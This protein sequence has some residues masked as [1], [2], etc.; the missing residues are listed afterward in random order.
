MKS[1]WVLTLLLFKT[2]VMLVTFFV[3]QLYHQPR[4][5]TRI[6]QKSG[7]MRNFTRSSSG[8]PHDFV[9]S[10]LLQNRIEVAQRRNTFADTASV[11]R[12]GTFNGLARYIGEALP[13]KTMILNSYRNTIGIGN[14]TFDVTARDNITSPEAIAYRYRVLQIGSDGQGDV[15][16]VVREWTPFTL[17]PVIEISPPLQ[18]SGSYEIEVQAR[19]SDGNSDPDPAST[20]FTIDV[21]S[22]RISIR[23][24]A[25]FEH[26]PAQASYQVIGNFDDNDLLQ[27][28]IHYRRA[29]AQ[30]WSDAGIT[31]PATIVDDILAV[32]ETPDAGCDLALYDFRVRARDSLG[33]ADSTMLKIYLDPLFKEQTMASEVGGALGS[34]CGT[35]GV[36]LYI[37]PKALAENVTFEIATLDSQNLCET[38]RNVL[39]AVSITAV[40]KSG[41]N[42]LLLE[43]DGTITL[44]HPDITGGDNGEGVMTIFYKPPGCEQ[45]WTPV[46]GTID[47]QRHTITQRFTATGAYLLGRDSR[48][49]VEIADANKPVVCRPRIFSVTGGPINRTEILFTVPGPDPEAVTVWVYNTSGR[50]VRKLKTEETVPP[51]EHAVTWDGH[52]DRGRACAGG[53]YLVVVLAGGEKQTAT[54]AIVNQ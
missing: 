35:K 26:I 11:L 47:A 30:S 34:I 45:P 2:A 27:Y 19:D 16:N 29:G 48:A 24:P 4:G 54:V 23:A 31:Y 52:D 3:H 13:P 51:G 10:L 20:S 40:E 53:F 39:F 14:P 44:K 25:E 6:D 8:L 36:E 41:E 42:P 38:P 7:E 1:E 5:V 43:K 15:K 49:E 28:E 32:W 17:G 22:P 46:G 9:F 37:P 12:F 21:R 50:L 18:E 33:H